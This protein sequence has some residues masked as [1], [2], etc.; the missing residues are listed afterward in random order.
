MYAGND[1]SPTLQAAYDEQYTDESA[2]WRELCARYKADN[3]EAV[4]SGRRFGRVLE[5]GAGEGSILKYLEADG[6]CSELAAIEIS[7]SGL[8]QIEKRRLLTRH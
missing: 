5:C 4:C 7:D 6:F 3:I 8:R 2:P 1:V